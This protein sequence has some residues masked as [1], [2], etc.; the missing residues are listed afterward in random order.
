[1]LIELCSA[2]LVL[3]LAYLW[4]LCHLKR[5]LNTMEN[6]LEQETHSVFRQFA[7]F[8]LSYVTRLAFYPWQIICDDSSCSSD[9]AIEISLCSLYL[10]W[11]ILPITYILIMHARTYRAVK[12]QL[13][14]MLSMDQ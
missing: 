7:F 4:T 9:Y 10:L 5:S 13:Q 6:Q 1:M 12:S 14:M 8:L 3:S 2:Y 11:N